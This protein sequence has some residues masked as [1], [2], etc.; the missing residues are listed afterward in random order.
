[1]KPLNDLDEQMKNEESTKL[2]FITPAIQKKWNAEGDRIVMEYGKKGSGHYFTDGQI[3]VG[4]DGTVKR[5]EQ[6][7][8]DYLLLFK[9]NLPLALVEANGFTCFQKLL[10]LPN[11]ASLVSNLIQ[12]I[13]ILDCMVI[14]R[15]NFDLL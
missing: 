1:M 2:N 15:W 4:A 3:L 7:K 5:G 11:N 12:V 13:N 9:N 14:S 10:S 6:K 8:V